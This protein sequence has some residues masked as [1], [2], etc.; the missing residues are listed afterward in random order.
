[1]INVADED[2]LKT[3]RSALFSELTEQLKPYHCFEKQPMYYMSR[4]AG[5][6]AI[7]ILMLVLIG[8]TSNPFL[9]LLLLSVDAI[10]IL[11]IGFIGHDLAH[12]SVKNTSFYRD[13]L[14]EFVWCFFLGLSKEFWDSKHSLHHKFTNIAAAVNGDPD[15]E[16]PPFVLGDLQPQPKSFLGAVI[17]KYQHIFYWMALSLLVVGL[18][19][20]SFIFVATQTFKNRPF[21]LKSPKS[22]V[23]LLIFTGYFANN[24]A[25]FLAKPLWLGFLLLAYKYLVTGFVIGFVFALNHVGLP[26]VSGTY[27]IDR[28]T[29]QTYTTR[30]V[31][32][33]FGRW[34]WG[35]LAYQTE[36]HLWPAI[37]WHKLPEAAAVTREFCQKHGIIYNEE[38][39]QQC[40]ID[41][42]ASLKKLGRPLD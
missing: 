34:F 13:Y 35:V 33:R 8:M 30:N 15:I 29:L 16:T 36:H 28:L 10:Y 37:S 26:V 4:F 9:C 21:P 24:F 17:T 23:F 42:V 3:D 5:Y 31:N 20:E 14:G 38:T 12:G 18:T 11:R 40:F 39:P 1:M 32:G 25:L 2:Y 41:S 27:P 19:V 6:V 22:V 7:H